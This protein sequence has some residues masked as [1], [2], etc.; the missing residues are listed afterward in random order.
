MF[1]T[2]RVQTEGRNVTRAVSPVALGEELNAGF[3]L[4]APSCCLFSSYG[5][6]SKFL[7]S[8]RARQRREL[9][10]ARMSFILL[11]IAEHAA[12]PADAIGEVPS[13]AP[14]NWLRDHP[15]CRIV[16]APF[17]SACATRL[18]THNQVDEL[19]FDS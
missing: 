10:A 3:H 12:A 5:S 13:G 15:K 16:T 19:R 17:P 8:I 6:F 2:L 14:E 4:N 9:P 11:G 7:S 1:I 18:E